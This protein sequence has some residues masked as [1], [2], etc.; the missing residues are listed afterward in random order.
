M[1]DRATGGHYFMAN[2]WYA[3]LMPGCCRVFSS[4]HSCVSHMVG[5]GTATGIM[6]KKKSAKQKH[7]DR[8]KDV[9]I[10]VNQ[11]KACGLF[12][13]SVVEKWEQSCDLGR[14]TVY[15][16]VKLAR[17]FGVVDKDKKVKLL[18]V[19]ECVES[20]WELIDRLTQEPGFSWDREAAML[21]AGE[22]FWGAVGKVN[23]RML[24][25]R[26]GQAQAA[27]KFDVERIQRDRDREA[28][29]GDS[30][31]TTGS[32]HG[33]RHLEA[34]YDLEAAEQARRMFPNV[35]LDNLSDMEDDEEEENTVG[36]NKK[37][38]GKNKNPE[39]VLNEDD[40][41]NKD[42]NSTLYPHEQQESHGKKN[43]KYAVKESEFARIARLPDLTQPIWRTDR[44][45]HRWD[46]TCLNTKKK[47]RLGIKITADD[48]RRQRDTDVACA[49]GKEVLK[50]TMY[51]R[52]KEHVAG[53]SFGLE[54]EQLGYGGTW[55]AFWEE[56]FASK[57]VQAA[58]G[59]EGEG[60]K[61]VMKEAMMSKKE[62]KKAA[63]SKGKQKKTTPPKE[64]ETEIQLQ[65]GIQVGVGADPSTQ[66]EQPELRR[67][68]VL[69]GASGDD[70]NA[71][72]Q[73]LF[74][75]PSV[76]PPPGGHGK[77][78]VDY[79]AFR[80]APQNVAPLAEVS[81]PSVD[82]ISKPPA[83]TS[84]N[85]KPITW[86]QY[87]NL[88]GAKA[89]KAAKHVLPPPGSTKNSGSTASASL[90]MQKQTPALTNDGKNG[91]HPDL[92][93]VNMPKLVAELTF[94]VEFN[95]ANPQKATKFTPVPNRPKVILKLLAE[96]TGVPEDDLDGVAPSY[97][98]ELLHM[99]DENF[100]KIENPCEGLGDG[101]C[102]QK[103]FGLLK[104]FLPPA[105]KRLSQS[106]RSPGVL[107]PGGAS[108]LGIL[109][110]NVIPTAEE[111]GVKVLSS[112]VDAGPG[113]SSAAAAATTTT[114]SRQ[115]L[116]P[117]R[118]GAAG[119]LGTSSTQ[120]GP[121]AYAA[122]NGN[123]SASASANTNSGKGAVATLRFNA[124]YNFQNS[125]AAA[126]MPKQ[127]VLANK[128]EVLRK[129]VADLTGIPEDALVD[130]GGGDASSIC[131]ARVAELLHVIDE[132]DFLPIE[133]N[134][135]G[136]DHTK[137]D[138]FVESFLEK[139]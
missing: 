30:G 81:W 17:T 66:W 135:I 34:D 123:A 98:A 108:S 84:W 31:G 50:T 136:C 35:D 107:Q 100:T 16:S 105:E 59:K 38:G 11:Q 2:Q 15:E 14:E 19:E 33:L 44:Q 114:H 10:P 9:P 60:Q 112:W 57:F 43:S 7:I 39:C 91:Q 127:T 54:F 80:A 139:L 6:E 27:G 97:A 46:A 110:R 70:V 20:V 85:A 109:R 52:A 12:D 87:S 67:L 122:V 49:L 25:V 56:H 28:L 90:Q 18:T 45:G 86:Q 37:G 115:V 32:S 88:P 74:E 22:P 119:C 95:K 126:H 116:P 13:P 121:S 134:R 72:Q 131:V 48:H 104:R 76:L 61:H 120:K 94:N 4:W 47:T 68:P 133:C 26:L 62:K 125:T 41:Y 111:L 89:P 124:R 129:V 75:G 92:Q 101:F 3:C 36:K 51:M 69:S 102:A 138:A 65:E 77:K 8:Y 63:A 58:V 93:G 24:K 113:T 21:K 83:A 79:S 42:T 132:E 55:E 29:G 53:Q 99:V 73:P 118:G 23:L 5:D 78:A 103:T 96:L 40:D 117:S 130:S 128:P 71:Q 106:P 137:T 64:T 1:R 82:E